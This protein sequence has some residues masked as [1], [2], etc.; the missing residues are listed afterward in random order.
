MAYGGKR[1]GAGRKAGAIAKKTREVAGALTQGSGMT[2]LDIMVASVRYFYQQAV[3]AEMVIEALGATRH[4]ELE[5]E[6]QFNAMQ[7]G[8]I[9]ESW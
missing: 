8:A 2:M 6:A 5:P 9:A 7:G 3:D 1:S 4:V